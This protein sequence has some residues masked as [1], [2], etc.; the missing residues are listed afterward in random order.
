VKKAKPIT[1]SSILAKCSRDGECRLWNGSINRR[2]YPQ[3]SIPGNGGPRTGSGMAPARP[4]VWALT[5]GAVPDGHRV[6]MTCGARLCL[7]RAHMVTLTHREVMRFAADSGAFDSPR[8][9]AARVANARSV[10][11]LTKETAA[12]IR[13]TVSA[14]PKSERSAVCKALAQAFSVDIRCIEQVA[15]GIRWAPIQI[16]NN[17]VFN[18]RA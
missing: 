3:L 15:R 8:Q 16:A 18:L 9:T 5:D 1:V 10:S 6:V 13:L 11:K 7:A 12:D 4:I 2:G 14:A 17:S